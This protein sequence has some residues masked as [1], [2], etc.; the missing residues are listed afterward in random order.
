MQ[1][2]K[3]FRPTGFD[4]KGLA[5]DDRQDWLVFLG[6]NRDSDIL[7]ESNFDAALKALGGEGDDVEIHRFG[8]WA[9][10]WFEVILIRPDS[11][12]ASLAV[13]MEV[14]LDGYPVLDESDFSQRET[15]E[16]DR[17]W[18]DCYSTAERIKYIARYRSQFEF[19]SMADMIGCV[20]GK[21]FAGYASE[22]I[23]R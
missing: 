22:L 6:R 7:T 5:L 18:S 17:I 9:C 23:N 3:D 13:D 19:R 12:A 1:R 16:A 2:Y 11:D 20:R 10:G 15:E 4:P 14:A 21:Y 8:H